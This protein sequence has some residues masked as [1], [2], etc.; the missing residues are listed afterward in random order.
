MNIPKK[1]PGVNLDHYVIMPNHVHLLLRIWAGEENSSEVEIGCIIQQMKGIVS[2]R[3][4]FSVW[5]KS[6]YDH[7]I[8]G[9]ADYYEI[10]QY[11]ENNPAKWILDKFYNE[12]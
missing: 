10:Y 5:Q 1:Y 7:I 8:R 2:K 9:D 4:R 12:V 3:A 6:Y 11:I